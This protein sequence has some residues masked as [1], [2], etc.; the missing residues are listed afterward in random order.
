MSGIFHMRPVSVGLDNSKSTI[1]DL[2]L[3][4]KVADF[5]TQALWYE[6]QHPNTLWVGLI[7]HFSIIKYLK[8]VYNKRCLLQLDF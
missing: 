1:D 8:Q 6:T 2:L 5:V 4:C 7:H 3:M